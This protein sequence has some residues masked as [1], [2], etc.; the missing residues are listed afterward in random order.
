MCWCLDLKWTPLY[1][2]RQLTTCILNSDALLKSRRD[3]ILRSYD[4]LLFQRHT[5]PPLQGRR[6]RQKAMLFRKVGNS[7]QATLQMHLRWQDDTR[8]AHC[9]VN[10]TYT[11]KAKLLVILN[12][13]GT[14]SLT[15]RKRNMRIHCWQVPQH[16]IHLFILVSVLQQVHSLFQSKFSTQ[17]DLLLPRSTSSTLFSPYGHPVAAYVLL[18]VFPSISVLPS[19]FPSITC[20]RRQFLRN[21]WQIY[22]VLPTFYCM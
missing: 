11:F 21:M 1:V 13:R 6:R 8:N 2:R 14:R 15:S 18:I 12:E 4:F 9:C 16:I 7:C 10:L 17:C 20:F 19:I 22:L 5:V 3:C